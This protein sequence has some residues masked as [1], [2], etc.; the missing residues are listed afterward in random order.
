MRN[1][2]KF[3]GVLLALGA[4]AVPSNALAS[5]TAVAN[6]PNYENTYHG[7]SFDGSVT[8][9]GDTISVTSWLEGYT[10]GPNG[11]W[12]TIAGTPYNV[13]NWAVVSSTW[14]FWKSSG[15]CGFDSPVYNGEIGACKK[16][17]VWSR[18]LRTVVKVQNHSTGLT[19]WK[20]STSR[21][22]C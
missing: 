10:G 9:T 12:P 18:E 3:V 14:T 1:V 16:C 7:V 2:R 22:V 19:F 15:Q 21:L 13:I 20:Y 5:C 17:P 8:C 4:L 11:S 6:P